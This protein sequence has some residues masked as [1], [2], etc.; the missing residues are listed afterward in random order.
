MKQVLWEYADNYIDGNFFPLEK[1]IWLCFVINLNDLPSS[2]LF[3]NGGELV[4]KPSEVKDRLPPRTRYRIR[5]GKNSIDGRQ[6]LATLLLG[7][8]KTR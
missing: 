1:W 3:V 4:S 7:D 6:L 2:K 8:L 5:V